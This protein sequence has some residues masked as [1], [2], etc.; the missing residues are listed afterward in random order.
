MA[1]R[2][3]DDGIFCRILYRLSE[4]SRNT[5]ILL[6]SQTLML[7]KNWNFKVFSADSLNYL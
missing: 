6:E 2:L 3:A 4:D 7:Q 5:L 1:M